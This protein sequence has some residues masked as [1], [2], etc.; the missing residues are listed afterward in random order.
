MAPALASRL[1][2]TAS[3]P[4]GGKKDGEKVRATAAATCAP[5]GSSS[6]G[7]GRNTVAVARRGLARRTRSAGQEAWMDVLDAPHVGCLSPPAR[8]RQQTPQDPL[9]IAPL[10]RTLHGHDAP[11]E[12]EERCG[13]AGRG[14]RRRAACSCR[15]GVYPQMRHYSEAAMARCLCLVG[16]LEEPGL[17]TRMCVAGHGMQQR[18]RRR[19]HHSQLSTQPVHRTRALAPCRA[20]RQTNNGPAVDLIHYVGHGGLAAGNRKGTKSTSSRRP[21]PFIRHPDEVNGLIDG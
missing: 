12:G 4:T 18:R 17:I 9:H 6:S 8:P 10:P 14:I 1:D 19:R 15:D 20:E 3:N 5:S 2:S 16:G 21:R 11:A 13:K 7:S